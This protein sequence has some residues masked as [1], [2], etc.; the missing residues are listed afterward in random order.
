MIST[1]LEVIVKNNE[2]DDTILKDLDS[3]LDNVIQLDRVCDGYFKFLCYVECEG[4]VLGHKEPKYKG[5]GGVS[6]SRL[7][8]KFESKLQGILEFLKTI[9]KYWNTIMEE[10]EM[11]F[12]ENLRWS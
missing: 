6:D 2:D 4:P 8:S 1:D 11:K 3:D 10:Q 5:Y 9:N 12:I 7:L